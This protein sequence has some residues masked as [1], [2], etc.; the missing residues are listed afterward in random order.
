MEQAPPPPRRRLRVS[1]LVIIVAAIAF[2][3][4]VLVAVVVFAGN[5]DSDEPDVISQP[6]AGP[7]VDALLAAG[8]A[9]DERI[10]AL[11]RQLQEDLATADEE[12]A[13]LTI[14]RENFI[15]IAEARQ[16][17]VEALSEITP[18]EPAAQAHADMIAAGEAYLAA[19]NEAVAELEDAETFED[20][21]AIILDPTLEEERSDFVDSC[22]ALVDFA[23]EQGAEIAV[24]C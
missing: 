13:R 10:A 9:L 8:R 2:F 20:A 22:A 7:Y 1:T 12:P 15:E 11:Q 5:D 17:L 14:V 21:Q 23:R 16:A 3:A 6:T 24:F 4:A 18:P 19:L